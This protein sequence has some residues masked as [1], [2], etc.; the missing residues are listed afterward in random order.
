[1]LRSYSHHVIGW[2]GCESGEVGVCTPRYNIDKRRVVVSTSGAV[3]V[4]T[5]QV[6]ADGES[7]GEVGVSVGWCKGGWSTA[8]ALSCSRQLDGGGDGDGDVHGADVEGG[9]STDRE[10]THTPLSCSFGGR[11]CD[12]SAVSIADA[13]VRA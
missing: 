6:S 12:V 9:R 2:R 8:R 4:P 11:G 1:M 10:S 7:G 13:T 5:G 3:L